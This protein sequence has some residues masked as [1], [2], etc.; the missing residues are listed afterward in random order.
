MIRHIEE[1]DKRGGGGRPDAKQQ[2][3]VLGRVLAH[4]FLGYKMNGITNALSP[5]TTHKQS[6]QHQT[7]RKMSDHKYV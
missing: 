4:K 7:N 5:V 2:G 6:D 1:E 3:R